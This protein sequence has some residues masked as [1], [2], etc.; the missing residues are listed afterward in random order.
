MKPDIGLEV[1]LSFK[2][3]GVPYEFNDA[4]QLLRDFLSEVNLILSKLDNGGN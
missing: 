3:K 4:Q 2:D 1:L